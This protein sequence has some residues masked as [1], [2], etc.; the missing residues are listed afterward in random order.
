MPESHV[1]S[2]LDACSNNESWIQ[3]Y[4]KKPKKIKTIF[5]TNF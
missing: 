3:E 5:F 2:G 1:T 4:V